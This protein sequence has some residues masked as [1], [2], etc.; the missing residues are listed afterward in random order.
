MEHHSPAYLKINP[1]GVI[2]TLIH[3]GRPLNESGTICEYLDEVFPEPPL[4]ARSWSSCSIAWR[5]R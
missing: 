4:R 3:D 5:R 2:P 1:N